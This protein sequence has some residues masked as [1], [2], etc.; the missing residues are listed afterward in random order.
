MLNPLLLSE[1]LNVINGLKSFKA[2]GYDN[3]PANFLKLG[4]EVLANVLYVYFAFVF[5][6]A[7]VIPIFKSGPRNSVN[8]YRPISI[9]PSLSKV[10]EKLIKTRLVN[11]S[12]KHD[13]FY[14]HQFGFREKRY[15]LHA[16][17]NVTSYCFDQIQNKKFSALM[18]MDL[19]KA[20][21]T[22]SHKILLKKTLSLRYSWSC[23]FIIM[24][25]SLKSST[26]RLC[27]FLQLYH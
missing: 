20:F 9:L 25:S 5:K 13:I 16:F 1:I 2:C 27:K 26:I 19:R 6:T 22:V 11:F 8:N 7:K 12:N 21:D 24:Q 14:D 3:I 23:S 15:V 18:L 10:L 4:G 17:L